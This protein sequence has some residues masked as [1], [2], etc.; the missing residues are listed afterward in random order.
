[1]ASA[2]NYDQSAAEYAVHRR[3]H[4]GVFRELSQRP[5]LGTTAV[6]LEVGCGTGNYA[7]ALAGRFS[8]ATYGLDPSAGMLGQAQAHRERIIWLLGRAEHLP[9]AGEA[10]DL[11]FSV[12]V[13]HH[14]TDKAA[15]YQQVRRTLRPGGRVCTVTDSEDIIQR[16]EILS[17]YFPETVE[18]ELARYPRLAQ[19][20]AWMARAGLEDLDVVTVEE[21][22]DLT[23]AQP[24]RDRAYSSLHLIAE[25]AWLAGLARLEHDLAHGPIPGIARYA[26]IWGRNAGE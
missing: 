3:V 9:F 4:S 8:C 21:P 20:Q 25:E 13:I 22:Y 26:C 6:V 7:R 12:D 16:R 19:V 18:I 11:I 5:R 24:F 15:F 2:V 23:G 1:M 17:G 14:I 10:F